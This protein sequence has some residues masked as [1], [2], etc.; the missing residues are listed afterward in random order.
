MSIL[1]LFAVKRL[2]IP[3]YSR[4]PLWNYNHYSIRKNKWCEQ[5]EL[6]WWVHALTQTIRLTIT[7]QYAHLKYVQ[8]IWDT[9]NTYSIGIHKNIDKKSMILEPLG[10]VS[11]TRH[12]DYV[13]QVS[14]IWFK[15]MGG[16]TPFN[17]PNARL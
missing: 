17:Q 3:Y 14:L 13:Q 7:Q 2:I 1:V 4:L 10:W 12:V 6:Q 11:S 8:V 9:Q 15:S 16:D 5:L